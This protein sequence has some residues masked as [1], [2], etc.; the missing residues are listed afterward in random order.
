MHGTSTSTATAAKYLIERLATKKAS[1]LSLSLHLSVSSPSCHNKILSMTRQPHSHSPRRNYHSLCSM[2][3]PNQ[4]RRRQ[5]Q[6]QQIRLLG[7]TSS[8]SRGGNGD[9]NNDRSSTNNNNNNKNIDPKDQHAFFQEQ[10]LELEAERTSFFAST[11]TSETETIQSTMASSITSNNDNNSNK[12]IFVE[13]LHEWKM[14]P[15]NV[16]GQE[17]VCENHSPTQPQQNLDDS[18]DE[19]YQEL[20]E[21]QKEER[22]LLF[23]FSSEEKAAWGQLPSQQ[24]MQDVLKRVQQARQQRQQNEEEMKQDVNN[25]NDTTVYDTKSSSVINS[26]DDSHHYHHESFSHVSSDG[27]SVHMVDVGDKAIT[28]RM[29]H[30]QSK[31]ILPATVLQAFSLSPSSQYS[32]TGTSKVQN[33]LIGPKGPIFA[34][35]KIAGIMAAKQTS[36]LIPLCHPLPIDQVI[37]DIVLQR[38]TIIIDCTCRVTHKTGVEMEALTG[39]T[40]AALTIY[41]MVKA[42]SHDVVLADTRLISKSGGK[43]HVSQQ[44][45]TNVVEKEDTTTTTTSSSSST[46]DDTSSSQLPTHLHVGP[47]GD[48]W[49]GNSIFAAKHLQ[50][51][52]VKS[53]PLFDSIVLQRHATRLV[54]LLEEQPLLAQQIYDTGQIPQ[55]VT[56]TLLQLERMEDP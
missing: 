10:L 13:Q 7:T 48:V 25:G 22:Q 36:D 40:V 53:I 46:A 20:L 31:V 35:A 33:E 32:S 18:S 27:N 6:Q 39:A 28:Q 47:S 9:N 41:D 29:A 16:F 4:R 8:P 43:R 11:S 50:P 44:D 12:N 51:D 3:T 15:T 24:S 38:D 14:E 5:Q 19:E 56:N 17:L 2:I 21:D 26:N 45:K 49:V 55:T 1:S 23:Q 30:A 52:Y 37:I 42:V 34:T 54:E